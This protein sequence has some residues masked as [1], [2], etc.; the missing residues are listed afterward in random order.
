MDIITELATRAHIISDEQAK[1]ASEI[2]LE[3]LHK[4]LVEYRAN[5]NGDYLGE[6]AHY[7]LSDKAFYHLLGF[8]DQFSKRYQWEEGDAYEYL[9]RLGPKER[10]ETFYEDIA[11]WKRDDQ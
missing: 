5:W 3:L 9:S 7:E 10:W 8:L 6:A 2:L 11:N 1:G 4:R